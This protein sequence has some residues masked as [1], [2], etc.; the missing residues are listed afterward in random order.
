M[1]NRSSWLLLVVVVTIS[2]AGGA[3]LLKPS[4]SGTELI[5]AGEKF[6]ATLAGEQQA[7]AT[8]GFDD[9]RRLDWHFIPKD[10]RKGLQ[11]KEM[12]EAQ[13]K[14]A[15]A[16]LRAGL[17]QAGYDKAT[18]VMSCEAIL[19]ELEKNKKGSP[20]RDTERY[21]ITVFG[22]PAL[23]GEWGF[24]VEGHHLSFNFVI[25]DGVLAST[26]PTFFGVNPAE[27]RT[28]IGGGPAKG[29][30]VLAKEEDLGF[31]LVNSLTDELKKQATI[32]EKAP[33]DIRAAGTTQAPDYAADGISASKLT[34]DQKEILHALI[35]TYI[36]NVPKEEQER[37]IAGLKEGGEDKIYFAWAG[38][39]KAGAGHYYRVQGP[40]FLI[41]FVNVQP[42]SAGN[43]ANHIHSVWRDLRGDFGI[44]R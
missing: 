37:R 29:H 4:Q 3:L 34:A 30:R 26:T 13:R 14:A 1:K 7:Q 6:V 5:A 11:I 23:Q 38:A 12:N 21:F 27:N 25:K 19:K 31:Q 39:T 16:L 24:S 20:L 43:P 18:T 22:K 33:A 8:M 36:D 17:S 42:D 41:E 44:K 15:H 2:A 28:D 40:S 32:A 35:G 9:K 10:T